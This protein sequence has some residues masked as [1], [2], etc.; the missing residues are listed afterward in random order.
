VSALRLVYARVSLGLLCELFGR[1]RQAYYKAQ[2]ARA[3]QQAVDSRETTVVLDAVHAIRKRLPRIGARKLWYLL[4]DALGNQ[5]VHLGRD[6]FY[7]MLR[8]AGPMLYPQVLRRPRTTNSKH[9]M[10]TYPSLI[11][12]LVI[13][14]PDQFYVSDI[15]YVE[16]QPHFCY[17]SL[18]T[19][20]YSH[21]IVGYALEDNLTADGPVRALAQALRQRRLQA[22]GTYLPLIHHADRGSQY[23]SG[24]YVK[25][26][27]HHGVDI[28]MTEH[29]SPYENA[30]TERLNGILKYEFG[31]VDGFNTHLEAIKQSIDVYNELRPHLSCNFLTPNQA[32][33]RSGKL[34]KQWKKK[35]FPETYLSTKTST[36]FRTGHFS[37]FILARTLWLRHWCRCNSPTNRQP[38]HAPV[39]GAATGNANIAF[40]GSRR[41]YACVSRSTKYSAKDSG[42][43]TK[44]ALRDTRSRFCFCA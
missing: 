10:R 34:L 30:I 19:D 28:S 13:D 11:T 8:T 18:I 12:D 24:R 38:N 22:D 25:I 4:K 37:S 40:T 41:L 44:E 21:K 14:R 33:Q 26:L 2:H 17:L 32:H 16:L 20:A 29:G 1:T 31:I 27:K 3:R 6:R 39:K 5:G 7:R 9:W 35:C 42:R 23:C 36:D 43:V 15:T